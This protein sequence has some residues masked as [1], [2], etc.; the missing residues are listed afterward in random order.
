MGPASDEDGDE[1]LITSKFAYGHFTLTQLLLVVN[2]KSLMDTQNA[3]SQMVYDVKVTI[4]DKYEAT[5]VCMLT[6]VV[7]QLE[8]VD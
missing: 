8:V 7:P 3:D 4:S 6:F 1:I 2:Q 5:S